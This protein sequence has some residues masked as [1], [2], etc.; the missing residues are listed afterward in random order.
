MNKLL[1]LSIFLVIASADQFWRGTNIGGW[2]VLE[3]WI[4]PSLF[5]R[6]LN[7][8]HNQ[9]ALDSY[10]VCE[11]LG[12][13]AGNKLMRDHWNSWYTDD[14]I[15]NLSTRGVNMVRLPIGDWTLNPYGP[16]VGCM[17]GAADMIDWMLDT[18]AKYN[19]SVLMDVHTAKDSQ[20]GFDN[21]GQAKQVT[22]KDDMHYKHEDKADWIGEFNMTTG[23]YGHL[24]FDNIQW[25]LKN[26]EALLKRY[27]NHS[28]FKGF[29]PINEPWW[30]TP[31]PVLKDFYRQVRTLVQRLAP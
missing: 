6:F 26:S 24:N 20:N 17:D 23:K 25:S 29:E 10:T 14:I 15:A 19:I 12:P 28:A 2:L 5:Y 7:K 27:G 30:N 21:S 22:W 9:T 1:I 16:Y 8:P 18:C 3:P 31:Q 13:T 4:T 11:S